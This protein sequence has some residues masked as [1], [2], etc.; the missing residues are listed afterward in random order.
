MG[1]V[2]Y[3]LLPW[4]AVSLSKEQK[5][6]LTKIL[7]QTASA[8]MKVPEPAI[9]VIIKENQSENVGVGGTLLSDR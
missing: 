9:T 7:T 2:Q 3:R 1:G 5:R 6:E 8:I 4:K